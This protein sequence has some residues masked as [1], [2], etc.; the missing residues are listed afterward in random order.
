M[1]VDIKI[2]YFI[3]F[4]CVVLVYNKLSK[5]V[6]TALNFSPNDT[7]CGSLLLIP[8]VVTSCLI[9]GPA[10]SYECGRGVLYFWLFFFNQEANIHIVI[11]IKFEIYGR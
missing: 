4:L 9:Y 8:E 1:N 7:K 11:N 6:G 3:L 5:M 10:G 2:D